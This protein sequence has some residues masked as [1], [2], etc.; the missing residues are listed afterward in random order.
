MRCVNFGT[1]ASYLA[2]FRDQF[3]ITESK[4]LNSFNI[5][6]VSFM[7][8]YPWDEMLIYLRRRLGTLSIGCIL[9][10]TAGSKT[11]WILISEKSGTWCSEH[12][13]N[14]CSI[15]TL[16][17]LISDHLERS[18]RQPSLHPNR[19]SCLWKKEIVTSVKVL[20]KK[21]HADDGICRRHL[22]SIKCARK[23]NNL[24]C[25]W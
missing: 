8:L 24:D 20:R 19:V 17:M 1:F 13:K 11:I 2:Y 10:T 3:F 18:R 5:T 4:K 14:E 23:C 9:S 12:P 25:F 21:K 6:V 7:S 22:W 16:N 15:R